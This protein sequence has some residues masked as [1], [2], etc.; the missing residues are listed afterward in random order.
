[1]QELQQAK[2][3]RNERKTKLHTAMAAQAT[4]NSEVRQMELAMNQCQVWCVCKATGKDMSLAA[5][6]CVVAPG[7]EQVCT[8]FVSIFVAAQH[9]F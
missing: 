9:S 8:M 7:V 3:L 2:Q 1:M 4:V 5:S 6:L